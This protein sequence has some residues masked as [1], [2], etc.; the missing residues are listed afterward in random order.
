M[1]RPKYEVADV[2]DRFIQPFSEQ[3]ALN[4]YMLGVLGALHNCRTAA[5]GGH[6]EKCDCCG[7]ERISYNS[8]RNRHCPKCQATN[9]AFWVEERMMQAPP[10]KHFHLVFTVPHELNAIC[11]LNNR[12]FYELM[13]TC[14]WET[15]RAFG[16]GYYGVESGAISVLHT[17]GQNLSFHPHIHC[18]VP[19]CGLTLAGNIRHISKNGK[20]LYPGYA[21]GQVFRGK[22]LQKLKQQLAADNRLAENQQLIDLA[23]GKQWVV[24]CEEPMC[25][26]EQIVGYLSQYTHRVAISNR[27]ILNIDNQNVTFAYKDY[28]DGSRQKVCKLSGV[29][30][31]RRFCMHILPKRFVRIRYYGIMSSRMKSVLPQKPPAPS[32]AETPQ[33]RM[34]RLTGFN[35]HQCPYC[36]KGQMHIV[37]ELPRIR[38]PGMVFSIIIKQRISA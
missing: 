22:L 29:E 26:P 6:R 17:W 20:Y 36:K 33:Q 24:H 37:A 19:A 12:Q 34:Q 28:R 8:C 31:L 1:E 32:I 15:L 9:Q 3:C 21:L 16:Y 30:F 10:V 38:S 5:L 27:R 25:G 7:K 35:V 4:S 2:I 23:Y 11:L 13:F 18:I 14:T